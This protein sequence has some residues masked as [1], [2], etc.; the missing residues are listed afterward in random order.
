MLNYPELVKELEEKDENA[1]NK[2]TIYRKISPY[3]LNMSIEDINVVV[4]YLHDTY[5]N[6]DD[7]NCSY[8]VFVDAALYVCNDDLSNLLFLIR[9]NSTKLEEQILGGSFLL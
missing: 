7:I 2:L 1:V 6:I 3:I 5:F 8:F 9:N 4:D